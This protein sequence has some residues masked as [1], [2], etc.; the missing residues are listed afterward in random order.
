MRKFHIILAAVATLLFGAACSKV[1]PTA[2]DPVDEAVSFEVANFMHRTKANV[3]FDTD[4]TF[5]TYSWLYTP[6]S[7]EAQSF[8]QPATVAYVKS[9]EV[10]KAVNRP[11]YWPKTGYLNFISYAQ[12]PAPS[13]VSE[14][15][16][17]G[18]GSAI[19][20]SYGAFGVNT[21]DQQI[22]P[23]YMEI[24]P[25]DDPLLAEA[26]YRYYRKTPEMWN[27]VTVDE[28]DPGF[29][30]VPTLFHHLAAKVTVIIRFDASQEPQ[31]GHEWYLQVNKA[32]FSCVKKGI[33]QAQ[34]EDPMV[35]GQ[36]WPFTDDDGVCWIP[37]KDDDSNAVLEN[38][39]AE[40]MGKQYAAGDAPDPLYLFGAF[41]EETEEYEGITVLPQYLDSGQTLSLNL[42]LTNTYQGES[43]IVETFDLP[44]AFYYGPNAQANHSFSNTI[45]AWKMGHH[46]VYTVTIKPN[47]TVSFDP[48][49]VNWETSATDYPY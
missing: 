25:N 26:A 23:V 36:S 29:T 6:D 4:K 32:S 45:D 1:V 42:T 3:A 47:S 21:Q 7:E 11:Y 24:K 5:T 48:A 22:D 16:L 27:D 28:G 37:R 31:N 41:N 39:D 49:V 34:F 13:D 44:I 43:P 10:W 46:Y 35:T 14:M 9:L 40:S 19:V 20:V 30:G 15:E 12:E 38:F 33:L 18:K 17:E 8:M 2:E